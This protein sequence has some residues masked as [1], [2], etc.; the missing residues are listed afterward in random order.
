LNDPLAWRG[1]KSNKSDFVDK[2][3]MLGNDFPSDRNHESELDRPWDEINVG[4]ARVLA[5]GRN[6]GI[7][8]SNLLIFVI[9]VL[10]FLNIGLEDNQD[11]L[12]VVRRGEV[13]EV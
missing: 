6:G 1:G 2:L 13:W 3:L 7:G 9:P 4:I 5:L 11:S 10:L 12:W 8:I